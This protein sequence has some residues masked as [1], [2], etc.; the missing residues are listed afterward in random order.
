MGAWSRAGGR[1]SFFVSLTGPA[2]ESCGSKWY[3]IERHGLRRLFPRKWIE[4]NTSSTPG[5][6]NLGIYIQ[7][8]FC[9]SKCTFCN[10]SSR[11]ERSTIFDQYTVALQR[12]MER[13]QPNFRSYAV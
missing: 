13:W 2:A 7:V 12:E 8:P 10:F 4:V 3:R 11:V 9:A 6:T 1:A 5:M